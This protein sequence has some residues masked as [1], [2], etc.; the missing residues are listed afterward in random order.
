MYLYSNQKEKDEEEIKENWEKK[1]ERGK[2]K[3]RHSNAISDIQV[4]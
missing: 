4:Y 3:K 2:P 1:K